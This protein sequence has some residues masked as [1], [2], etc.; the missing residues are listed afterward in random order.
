[1]ILVLICLAMACLL[2]AMVFDILYYRIPN[3]VV[4]ALAGSA[5]L[6]A[7]VSRFCEATVFIPGWQGAL[8]VLAIG[9][10]LFRLGLVGGGDVKLLAACALWFPVGMGMVLFV[11]ACAGGLFALGLLL[12]ARLKAKPVTVMPY[13]V[14][15]GV[16][17][18][19][20]LGNLLCATVG[21]C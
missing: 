21:A 8:L 20:G 15:I 9:L 16:G 18:L 13:G 12:K 19:V 1:M 2:A 6:R 11:T 7:I 3:W 14:A 5:L 17:G 10:V 4:A